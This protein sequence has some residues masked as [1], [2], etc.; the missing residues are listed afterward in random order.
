MSDQ[1][2][3]QAIISYINESKGIPV[4]ASA[5][6]Q[7]WALTL[8]AY[9]RTLSRL[10][11]ITA[12]SSDCLPGELIHLVNHLVSIPLTA[13]EVKSLTEKK[14]VLAQVKRFV[15]S[16]WPSQPLG[17]DFQPYVSKCN[18]LSIWDGWLLWGSRLTNAQ[19]EQVYS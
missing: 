14:P 12:T 4:M 13:S 11:L 8:S 10:T 3:Q 9:N 15:M 16:G 17:N 19:I 2:R 5:R 1:V 7:S 6:L 18:E